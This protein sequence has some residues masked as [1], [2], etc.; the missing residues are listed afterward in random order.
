MNRSFVPVEAQPT[1][2]IED[3]FH[4]FGAIALGIGILDSQDERA[5]LVSRKQ[6]VE[7]GRA[8]AADVEIARRRGRKTHANSARGWLRVGS[9]SVGVGKIFRRICW[10]AHSVLFRQDCFSGALLLFRAFSGAFKVARS[11]TSYPMRRALDHQETGRGWQWAAIT[12]KSTG[13]RAMF[14]DGTPVPLTL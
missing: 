8:R 10:I 2:T 13:R 6:P 9:G 3:A 12:A 5:A 7:K 4:Q 11:E 14:Q 1:Q